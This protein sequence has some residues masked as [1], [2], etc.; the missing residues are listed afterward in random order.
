MLSC[1]CPESTRGE[2]HSERDLDDQQ[3]LRVF[4]RILGD[5]L[6]DEVTDLNLTTERSDVAGWDSFAYI[7][8]IVAVELE[9]G[10]KF[11]TAEIESFPNVGAILETVKSK[12][13]RLN[14]TG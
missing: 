4:T 10:V 11:H 8:F 7:N 13:P 9:F 3:I 12:H 5:I 6:P 14:P 1:P 2:G